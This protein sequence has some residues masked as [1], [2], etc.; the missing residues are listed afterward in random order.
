MSG[1]NA[2]NQL[3]QKSM[4]YKFSVQLKQIFVQNW[5]IKIYAT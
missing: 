5:K 2:S 3:Y 4:V 1:L